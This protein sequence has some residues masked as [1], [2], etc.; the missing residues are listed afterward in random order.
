MPVLIKLVKSAN[1]KKKWTATFRM[2]GNKFKSVSFG[3]PNLEDYLQHKDVERRDRYLKRHARDLRTNDP[4]RPGFL[5]YF[6]TWSGFEQ[7]GKPTTDK[8]K[9]IKMY[10]AKFFKK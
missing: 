10:N 9:L 8:R 7:S 2:P 5:A 4:L 3:D 6:L 1:P